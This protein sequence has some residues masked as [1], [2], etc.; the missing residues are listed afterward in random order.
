MAHLVNSDASAVDGKAIHVGLNTVISTYT[1][2]ETASGSTTIAV[3]SLPAG[4]E[5]VSAMVRA[6]HAALN[7]GA[8]AGAVRLYPTIGGNSVG[9]IINT[10]TLSYQIQSGTAGNNESGLGV[11]LTGSAN[12]ILNIN[13]VNGTGTASTV[14][15]VICQYL[16][17][18]E[19]D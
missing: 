17:E 3:M 16:A 10:S 9:D 18:Q 19:G 13:G 1:L 8:A 15:T 14:F 4:G 2:G 5:I 6:N 11:R 7:I 12:L